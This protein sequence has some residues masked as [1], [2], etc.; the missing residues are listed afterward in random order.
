MGEERLEEGLERKEGGR[1][2]TVMELEIINFLKSKKKRKK[3]MHK[4]NLTGPFKYWVLEKHHFFF[5][6]LGT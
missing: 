2:R 4:S 1:G 3:T 5:L 6:L